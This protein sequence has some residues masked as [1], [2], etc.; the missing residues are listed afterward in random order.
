M[1]DIKDVAA[2]ELREAWRAIRDGR[3]RTPDPEIGPQSLSAP[4]RWGPGSGE[5]VVPVVKAG[6]GCGSSTLAAA[7]ASA[8][9][10]GARVVE[11]G[12]TT[13]AG[14][15]AASTAE[16][17]RHPSGWA[18][19]TRGPVLLE[20]AADRSAGA[21]RI[22]VPLTPDRPIRLTMLDVSFELGQLLASTAWIG[23]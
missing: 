22:P 21:E 15:A 11:C 4:Q 23:Q 12:S 17:G 18:R 7:I 6:G 16:L 10:A 9:A 20:W 13:T 3:F 19:G 8:A 1:S 14:L 2:L 5:Q